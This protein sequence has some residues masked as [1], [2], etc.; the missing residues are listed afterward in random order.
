MKLITEL[1]NYFLNHKSNETW[2]TKD[3]ENMLQITLT[4]LET[5]FN[6]NP[7]PSISYLGTNIVENF[8]SVIRSK[9]LYPNFYEFSIVYYKAWVELV[10]IFTKNPPIPYSERKLSGKKYNNQNGIEFDQDYM[11]SLMKTENKKASIKE[12]ISENKGKKKN[13]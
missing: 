1:K 11:Y 10:K 5:R 13:K 7:S 9:I 12:L 3:V 2:I 6:T 4:N 8:F